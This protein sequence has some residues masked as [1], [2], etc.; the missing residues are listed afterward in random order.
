MC[1]S[2]NEMSCALGGGGEEA[3]LKSQK[4][5]LNIIIGKGEET[6]CLMSE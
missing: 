2:P 1:R 3:S 4:E 5:L 6:S